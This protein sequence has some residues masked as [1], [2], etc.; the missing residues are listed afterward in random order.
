M[1]YKPTKEEIEFMKQEVKSMKS[2]E[3]KTEVCPSIQY[4]PTPTNQEMESMEIDK[5]EEAKRYNVSVNGVH[6]FSGIPTVSCPVGDVS[7]DGAPYLHFHSIN[8]ADKNSLGVIRTT[9]IDSLMIVPVSAVKKDIP[10]FPGPEDERWVETNKGRGC[11]SLGKWI[12]ERTGEHYTEGNPL[13][14]Q[15]EITAWW[16]VGSQPEPPKEE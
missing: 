7:I 6:I 3:V 1:K 9:G 5:K 11:Y 15:D 12:V 2:E 14:G 16:E 10:H 4:E 8:G 13:W